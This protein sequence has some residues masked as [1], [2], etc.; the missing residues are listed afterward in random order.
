MRVDL[1]GVNAELLLSNTDDN[2]ERLVN[3]ELGDVVSLETSPL[4]GGGESK[5]RRLGEV[6]R[7]DTGVGVCYQIR[8]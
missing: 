8:L 1:R 4:E 2:G 6:D 5:C 7:I 3:L